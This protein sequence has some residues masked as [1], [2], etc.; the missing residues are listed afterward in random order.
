MVDIQRRVELRVT[1][2]DWWFVRSRQIGYAVI[3]VDAQ[4]DLQVMMRVGGQERLLY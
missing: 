3:I 1:W 2:S 4:V